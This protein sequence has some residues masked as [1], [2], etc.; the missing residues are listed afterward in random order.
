[1]K[2]KK[3][4]YYVVK[5]P[6]TSK[7][8]FDN[9][10]YVGKYVERTINGSYLMQIRKLRRALHDGNGFSSKKYREK[11]VWYFIISDIME[12]TGRKR[13]CDTEIELFKYLL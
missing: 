5:N 9:E 7:I 1:M 11:D 10:Y 12:E 13:K 6:H 4:Y 8:I 3:G 2:L